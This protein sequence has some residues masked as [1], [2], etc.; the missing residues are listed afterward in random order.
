MGRNTTKKPLRNNYKTI[1]N[2]TSDQFLYWL[3]GFMEVANPK[4]LNESQ[5][6]IIRDHLNLV[7]DKKTPIVYPE[8][9]PTSPNLGHPIWEIDPNY[10]RPICSSNVNTTT[11]A[12]KEDDFKMDYKELTK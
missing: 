7:F 6:Q 12:G 4:T 5:V 10:Y 3:Q 11:T 9:S 1:N 8:K 2:M